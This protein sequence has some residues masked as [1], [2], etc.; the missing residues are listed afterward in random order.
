MLFLAGLFM[1]LI[2]TICSILFHKRVSIET[3]T[4]L[5]KVMFVGIMIMVFSFVI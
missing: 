5:F 1:F 4:T 2:G 3:N